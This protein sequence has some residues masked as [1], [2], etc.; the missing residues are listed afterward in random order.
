M[1]ELVP[2]RSAG[3]FDSW[4]YD[5]VQAAAVSRA[6]S[7]R[8]RLR[9][10]AFDLPP[11]QGVRVLARRTWLEFGGL[12]KYAADVPVR[13]VLSGLRVC[14]GPLDSVL[15]PIQESGASQDEPPPPHDGGAPQEE[16]EE[17][18]ASASEDGWAED[19]GS[20]SSIYTSASGQAAACYHPLS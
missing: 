7:S 15:E 5:E 4:V 10:M 19:S 18:E 14:R 8:V 2:A 12:E 17:E 6:S 16:E 11:S 20:S 1:L 3:H 13:L 9:R